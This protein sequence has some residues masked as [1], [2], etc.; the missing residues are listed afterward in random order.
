MTE[1]WRI[2]EPCGVGSLPLPGGSEPSEVGRAHR[3]PAH[4]SF[5]LFC[6]SVRLLA[7]TPA[8]PSRGTVSLQ[9]VSQT[10][11]S[12]LTKHQL[13]CWL[14]IALNTEFQQDLSAL[15]QSSLSYTS[16]WNTAKNFHNSTFPIL[17]NSRKCVHVHLFNMCWDS[18]FRCSYWIWWIKSFIHSVPILEGY[19]KTSVA[20]SS[21]MQLWRLKFESPK[22]H[23]LG[24]HKGIY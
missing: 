16:S 20:K 15:P 8:C 24:G 13:T 6:H 9:T 19:R 10:T 3:H 14:L 12:S 2:A 22:P 17:A 21:A 7:H 5:F 18:N 11:L 4:L 1:F 23:I